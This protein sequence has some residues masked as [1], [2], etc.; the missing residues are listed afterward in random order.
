MKQLLFLALVG[1]ALVFADEACRHIVSADGASRYDLSWF[2]AQSTH[3]PLKGTTG[4]DTYE[5]EF[6]VC[7]PGFECG[8]S[9]CTGLAPKGGSC[10]SWGD[11]MSKDS[12]ACLGANVPSAIVG[13]NNGEGVTLT[14]ANGDEYKSNPRT[15]NLVLKC[16]KTQ[17]DWGTVTFDDSK[18]LDL[19]FT[20]TVVSEHAC[21]GSGGGATTGMSIGTILLIV[22]VCAIPAYLIAVIIFNKVKGEASGAELIPNLQFWKAL[23]GYVKDG[24][25]FY[26][27]TWRRQLQSSITNTHIYTVIASSLVLNFV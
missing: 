20:V 25:F 7:G 4:G 22:I 6:E 12:E 14:Y 17:K 21:P 27:S 23:P 18:Q 2:M 19:L 13:L 9:A 3:G 5:Y 1:F 8:L 24:F 11:F 10:Q 16:D 26:Y 15:T